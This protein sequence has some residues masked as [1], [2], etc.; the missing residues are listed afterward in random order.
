MIPYATTEHDGP[1]QLPPAD[2]P[3]VAG[4][5]TVMDGVVYPRRPTVVATSLRL[6]GGCGSGSSRWIRPFSA[7][8]SSRIASH[9]LGAITDTTPMARPTIAFTLA[10]V[11]GLADAPIPGLASIQTLR[12]LCQ[13]LGIVI[14]IFFAIMPIYPQDLPYITPV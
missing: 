1:C 4:F 5:A 6:H 11:S 7:R 3:R 13:V 10:Q 14:S 9:E 12:F 8:G 2:D